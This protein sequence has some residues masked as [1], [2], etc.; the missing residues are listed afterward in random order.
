M[1]MG[2]VNEHVDDADADW[3]ILH[4]F[5][6]W[7][8]EMTGSEQKAGFAV[9]VGTRLALNRYRRRHHSHGLIHHCDD[10]GAGGH[11]EQMAWKTCRA[12]VSKCQ[13]T[14]LQL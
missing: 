9:D 11:P 7:R 8:E 5:C 10:D 4:Q 2:H 14:I 12:T 3:R 6:R 13:Y 1:L